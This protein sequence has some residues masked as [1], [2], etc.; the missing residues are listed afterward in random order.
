VDDFLTRNQ[1]VYR[2]GWKYCAIEFILGNPDGFLPPCYNRAPYY[3]RKRVEAAE[4]NADFAGEV[5]RAEENERRQRQQREDDWKAKQAKQVA[6]EAERMNAL[7]N[8][9]RVTRAD[10]QRATAML[11]SEGSAYWVDEICQT[12]KAAKAARTAKLYKRIGQCGTVGPIA[13]ILLR[14]QI[15]SEKGKKYRGDSSG[16]SYAKKSECMAGLCAVLKDQQQIDYGWGIDRKC[17][18]EHVLYV[19]LPNGQVSFHCFDRIGGPDYPKQWD[20]A[21]ASGKR[22]R[23]FAASVLAAGTACLYRPR[24]RFDCFCVIGQ[25]RGS[26]P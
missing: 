15:S 24:V 13:E 9:P 17:D 14:V 4:A 22:I 20:G 6:K 25:G 12:I 8:L 10:L 3:S 18:A 5:A 21:H 7:E 16:F 1:I 23:E 2:H 26:K 19:D 11:G